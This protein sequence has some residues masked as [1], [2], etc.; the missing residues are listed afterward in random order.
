M[1]VYYRDVKN[2][3]FQLEKMTNILDEILLELNK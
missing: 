3:S 1:K 2:I